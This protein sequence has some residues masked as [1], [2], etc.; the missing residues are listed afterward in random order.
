MIRRGS[1]VVG[2]TVTKLSSAR[3]M[4]LWDQIQTSERSETAR[5]LARELPLQE[6][7]RASVERA[8]PKEIVMEPA[9]L[10]VITPEYTALAP[11]V[12]TDKMQILGDVIAP[13]LTPEQLEV[14]ALACNRTRLDPFAKQICAVMRWDS[15]LGRN[16]MTIQTTIDGFRVIAERTGKYGGRKPFE[17]CG[18]DGEWKEVWLDNKPPAAARA[19]I[20]RKDFSEPV[21]AIARY[22]AYAALKRD[23]SPTYMWNKMD[24]EQLAKCAEALG[25]RTAF[26]QELSGLYTEDEMAQADKPEPEPKPAAVSGNG[27]KP[28]AQAQPKPE[29]K[30]PAP[31]PPASTT[32]PDAGPMFA[33]SFPIKIWS[34]KPMRSADSEA[35][36]DYIAWCEGVIGDRSRSGLHKA[37]K[38]SMQQAETV[39]SEIVQRQA[40]AATPPAPEETTQRIELG[41]DAINAAMDAEYARTHRAIGAPTHRSNTEIP[42]DDD[43]PY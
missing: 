41:V 19:R 27:G 32:P 13:G 17:W 5:V 29:P 30:K 2:G 11:V 16:K 22:K 38:L 43:I 18:P 36:R 23:G 9:T 8:A 33:R 42:N 14:F 37:A 34:G 10:A 28:P 3:R 24:A 35:L 25:L 26:P 7:L 6:Q 21:V 39:Y 1:K 15:D 4:S 20:L 12:P 40:A 31:P